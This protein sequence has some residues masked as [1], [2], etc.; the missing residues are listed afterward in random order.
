[1]FGSTD[2]KLRSG[3]VLPVASVVSRPERRV[4]GDADAV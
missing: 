4:H 3:I 1:L 2:L